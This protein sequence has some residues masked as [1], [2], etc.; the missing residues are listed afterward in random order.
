MKKTIFEIGEDRVIAETKFLTLIERPF[1]NTRTA[2][3]GV[4]C[5]TESPAVPRRVIG[6]IGITPDN[7]LVCIEIYRIAQKAFVYEPIVGIVDDGE[8]PEDAASRELLEEVGYSSSEMVPLGPILFDP[9]MRAQKVDLY[10]ARNAVKVAEPELENAEDIHV[11]LIPLADA[12]A[13]LQS[14][15]KA[16]KNVSASLLAA[17]LFV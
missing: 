7:F 8:A 3:P 2:K 14:E 4:W 11:M 15:A 9:G 6:C 10:L 5:M 16:G 17:L 12:R 1:H 13:F